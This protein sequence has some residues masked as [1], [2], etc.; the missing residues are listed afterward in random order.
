M[1]QGISFLPN[2]NIIPINSN[3]SPVPQSDSG[4][5]FRDVLA[6]NKQNSIVTAISSGSQRD[7]IMDAINQAR[8]LASP[9]F[10]ATPA[11]AI[12][13]KFSIQDHYSMPPEDVKPILTQLQEEILKTDFSGMTNKEIYELIENKFIEAFGEDFMMGF[14]LLQIVPDSGM[15]NDPNREISN[16]EYIDIGRTFND[17]V[18]GKVGHDEMFSINRERLYGNMSYGEIID[19]IIAKHPQRL[20]NRDLALITAEMRS[21]GINDD[22]GF[23]RYVEE[24]LW[25]SGA[26]TTKGTAPDWNDFEKRWNSLLNNPAN[27]QQ[28]AYMQ[29]KTL[30]DS[31]RNPYVQRT[32][33]VLEK[34]GA[35][36]GPNGY[37]LNPDGTPFVD[38]DVEIGTI[39][40]DE[41]TDEYLKALE[42]HDK[43]L[44]ESRERLENNRA[45]KE[46]NDELS[47]RTDNTTTK[48]QRKESSNDK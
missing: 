16:Y 22:I 37:F 4:I 23:D 10:N 38:L 44:Y 13:E 12:R 28:M 25:K 2:R 40:S 6:N 21:I 14:N 18:G 1:I 43:S 31:P 29:N 3:F 34:L 35:E 32:R 8:I 24:L 5:S 15:Y 41:L 7:S 27:V 17:L 33:E 46:V 20:T 39:D 11:G 42:R 47:I 26:Q 48:T 30:K 9:S 36:L 19:T 45:S